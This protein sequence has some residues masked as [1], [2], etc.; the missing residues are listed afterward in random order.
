MQATALKPLAGLRIVVTR[1]VQQAHALSETLRKLGAKTIELPTIEIIRVEDP[2]RLDRALRNLKNYD[3]VIFTSVHG[4]RFFLERLRVLKISP[5]SLIPLKVAAIGPATAATIERAGKR[6]DF[7]PKEYISER[8]ALGLGAVRGKRILLPRA[9]IAS[10]KLPALLRERGGS[11][12][13]VI[14][15][16]TVIPRGFTP[17]RLKSVL[18]DGVDVITFTSPST[19]RNVARVLGDAEG[20]NFLRKVKVACIGPVT[21]QAAEE[22]GL[23]VD[24]V[25]KTHTINA[26]VEAIVDEARTV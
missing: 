3:W 25:A 12:D 5:E 19:V 17:E 13:E 23:D 6:P 4:V 7:V 21:A 16:R 8:I 18:A 22:V 10:R 9:D 20:Q 2:S 15:Y 14:A 26:L 11:V 1:P 24:V